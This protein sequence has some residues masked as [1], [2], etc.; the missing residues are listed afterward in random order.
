MMFTRKSACKSH[1]AGA[2][3]LAELMITLVIISILSSVALVAFKGSQ[4]D[5]GLQA[6]ADRL[7]SDL[8]QVRQQA[9]QDQRAYQ[10]VFNVNDRSYQSPALDPVSLRVLQVNLQVPP[11]ELTSL[12]LA[13]ANQN[14]ISF[15]R[16]GE[17]TPTGS[18]TLVRGNKSRTII[19]EETGRVDPQ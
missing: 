5:T 13:L 18:I 1:S 3:S 2:L 12:N 8:R 7:L 10:V 15:N 11:Y 17:P 16:Q 4:E 6:A 14:I 9:L 19:L